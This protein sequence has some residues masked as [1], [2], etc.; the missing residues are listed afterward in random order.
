MEESYQT[1]IDRLE[2]QPHAEGGFYRETYRC[3]ELLTGLP[4]RGTRSASTAI[5]F[6]SHLDTFRR[7]IGSKATRCGTS[8]PARRF[9]SLNYQWMER[10]TIIGLG[11]AL[12]GLDCQAVV[13]SGSWFG[14]FA[15]AVAQT[16]KSAPP[17]QKSQNLPRIDIPCA[18]EVEYGTT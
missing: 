8:T 7:C 4:G 16:R 17:R 1:L 6:C 13:C 15:Y 11:N 10:A 18:V 5:L 3:P 2:L 14:A 12:D 9:E